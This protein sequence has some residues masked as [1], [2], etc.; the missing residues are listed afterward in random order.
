VKRYRAIAEYYDAEYERHPALKHDVPF[1]LKSIPRRPAQT[2]LE[3]AVGTGRVAIPL[4]KAG[5]TVVGVDYASDMLRIAR[6]KRDAAGISARQLSFVNQSILR[7]N[8]H[9]QFDWIVLMFNTFLAFPTLKEQDAVL[10]SVVRHLKPGGKFWVQMFQPNLEILSKPK[11]EK[12][13]PALLYVPKLKRTVYRETT[14]IRDQAKQTQE[15]IFTYRWFNSKGREQEQ[16]LRF[17]L[18]YI[19]PRELRIVLER[20]GLRIERMYGDYDGSPLTADSPRII[21]VCGHLKSRR[22]G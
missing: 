13:D 20:N 3:L 15:V 4:A 22:K 1:L 12:L 5:H 16:Q 7:L 14:V 19:F 10:R 9:R 21:A 8:L 6:R 2:I 11:S 17:G 18:T